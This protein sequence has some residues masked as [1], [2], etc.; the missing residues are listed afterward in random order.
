MP[1]DEI[2]HQSMFIVGLIKDA[3]SLQIRRN[4]LISINESELTDYADEE[5]IAEEVAS[6][7]RLFNRHKWPVLD[8]S[9]R[10]VEETAAAIINLH[11]RWLEEKEADRDQDPNHDTNQTPDD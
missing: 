7:R 11:S 1:L 8:V 4:R 6:A 3:R 10:S 9:R 2:P 5:K